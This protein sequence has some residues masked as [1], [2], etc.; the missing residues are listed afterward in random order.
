MSV[1]DH[2]GDWQ[3]MTACSRTR[4]QPASGRFG[5]WLFWGWLNPS[6]QA[7]KMAFWSNKTAKSANKMSSAKRQFSGFDC[8]K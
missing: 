8:R 1:K 4:L 5:V 2:G 6:P 3:K 7:N